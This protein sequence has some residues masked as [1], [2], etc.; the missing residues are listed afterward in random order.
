MPKHILQVNQPMF[1][2]Q[3]DR[4][5]SEKVTEILNR[6]PDASGRRDHRRGPLRAFLR[7]EGVSCRPLRT[8]SDGQGR[9]IGSSQT[10]V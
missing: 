7:Q 9:Q 2:T 6:M 1:E 8:R 4:M 5:V 3:L 10:R